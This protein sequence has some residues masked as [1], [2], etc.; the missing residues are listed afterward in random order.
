MQ[1]Q[2]LAQQIQDYSQKLSILEDTV[3]H[4]K[5]DPDKFSFE[6]G[7]KITLGEIK[8]TSKL[9][10]FKTAALKSVFVEKQS[11]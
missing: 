9:S 11:I 4:V 6:A 7:N 5:A 2:D 10:A 1:K 8:P 3:I